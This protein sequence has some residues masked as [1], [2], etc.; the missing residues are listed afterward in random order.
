M[1]KAL[2]LIPAAALLLCGCADETEKVPPTKEEIAKAC[3]NSVDATYKKAVDGLSLDLT[4]SDLDVFYGFEYRYY[5]GQYS[6]GKKYSIDVK[7][8]GF[9]LSI[10]ARNL[11]KKV[12]EWEASIVVKDLNCT[13]T[14]TFLDNNVVMDNYKISDIGFGAYLKGGN[15]YLNLGDSN[16]KETAKTIINAVA[17]SSEREQYLSVVD[18][19]ANDYVVYNL[20]DLLDQMIFGISDNGGG[21]RAAVPSIIGQISAPA[22]LP[23]DILQDLEESVV[24]GLTELDKLVP[25]MSNLLNVEINDSALSKINLKVAKTDLSSS[26]ASYVADNSQAELIVN[27]ADKVLKDATLIVDAKVDVTTHSDSYSTNHYLVN[28]KGKAELSVNYPTSEI[29]MPDFES[30]E[31]LTPEMIYELIGNF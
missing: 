20:P 25:G 15:L 4:V 14:V 6:R 2:L 12:N 24:S 1:K 16:L 9:T 28:A 27:F 10:N 11:T 17:G 7:D 13:E 23:E 19:L 26:I 8:L 31:E 29:V 18:A 3:R 30:Y 22:V 21:I 5:D